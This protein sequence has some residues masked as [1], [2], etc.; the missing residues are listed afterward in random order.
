MNIDAKRRAFSLRH[1][2]TGRTPPGAG[3]GAPRP[4]GKGMRSN[5]NANEAPSRAAA[6]NHGAG[7]RVGRE[8]KGRAGKGVTVVTGLPL[9]GEA[10]QALAA[11]L[12]KRCG[13]GGTIRDG[14]VE[15]QGDHRD[16]V[17][18]ILVGLGYPAK[19]SGG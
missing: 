9:A 18:A 1:G 14:K 12:K 13:S 15:I 5:A 4:A 11:D 6:V 19:R 7:V 10:L 8:T 16:A 3:A 17:V 2:T